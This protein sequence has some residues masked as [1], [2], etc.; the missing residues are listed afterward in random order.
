MSSYLNRGRYDGSD[1]P[2]EMEKEHER[3]QAHRRLFG[4][5]HEWWPE[6]Q[7]PKLTEELRDKLRCLAENQLPREEALDVQ[8]LTL[9]FRSIA[10]CYGDFLARI[11]RKKNQESN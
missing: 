4:L 6:S 3:R 8:E 9:K 10:A 1:S 7:A 11:C 2:E 5:D